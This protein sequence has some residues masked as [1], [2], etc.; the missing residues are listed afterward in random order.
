MILVKDIHMAKKQ[1]IKN[2]TV[3]SIEVQKN[4][5]HRLPPMGRILGKFGPSST[6]Q[7]ASYISNDLV[8]GVQPPNFFIYKIDYA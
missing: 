7:R 2:S 1:Y 6:G 3:G 5:K 8:P 4:D